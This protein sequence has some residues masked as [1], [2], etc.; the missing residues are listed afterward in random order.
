MTGLRT[1][2]PR[3]ANGKDEVLV[4]HILT[5]RGGFPQN[6]QD[7]PMQEW[8]NLQRVNSVIEALPV[9][10]PPGTVSA[11]HFLT[12]HWVIASSYACSMDA[13]TNVICKRKFSIHLDSGIPISWCHLSSSIAA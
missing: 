13:S 12:Q 2:G 7:L 5:H 9:D 1:I 3:S 6:P 11:Y 8:G 10:F 4:R